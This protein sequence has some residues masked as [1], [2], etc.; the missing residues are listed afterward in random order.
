M[1]KYL[2]MAVAAL[3]VVLGGLYFYLSRPDVAQLPES[4]LEGREPKFTEPRKQI[5]P[6]MVIAK[7]VGWAGNAMPVAAKGLTVNRFIGDLDHPRTMLGLPN[8][9]VLVAETNSPPRKTTGIKS[10][11]TNLLMGSAGAGGASANRILL[12][13][14]KNGDGIAEERHVFLK[15]LNSPYGMALLDGTLYVAN[16][17]SLMAYPYVEGAT[18]ITVAGRKISNLPANEPNYHWTKSLTVSPDGK[19]Y[20]GVGSNS[21]IGENG[22]DA[23]VN[24][25]NVL[26]ITPKTGSFNIF[27]SGL[28]NPTDLAWNPWTGDLWG[29]VNERDMIGSDLVPDYLTEVEFAAFYGWPWNYWGGYED[30]RVQP[31]RPELREYTKRPD[32]GLGVHVAPLSVTFSSGAALGAPFDH[33][34][35]IGLHGSWNRK[36]AAGYKVVYV[37]FDEKGAPT[38]KPVDLLTGFLN[39]EGQAQGRPVDVLVNKDGSILVSDDV[40][41]MIWRISNRSVP[42]PVAA[43]S[44]IATPTPA[45]K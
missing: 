22:L 33:G 38:G 26:E 45:A 32:F 30:K 10:W 34:A 31:E 9:D 44:G 29:V 15:G 21:N 20:V 11:V 8:G 2:I 35:F 39:G 28:R 6:T 24:R 5:L 42:K 25:A 1:K 37:A 19:L 27:A 43:K 7:P 16:T 14:D 36:P 18:Q 4:A 40:G 17:D 12:L 23:E 41:G 13:R 3:V